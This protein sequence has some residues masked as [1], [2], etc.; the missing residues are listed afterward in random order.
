MPI[1]PAVPDDVAAVASLEERCLGRDA[2]SQGL[3]RE[4]ITGELPTVAYLVAEHEDEVVGHAVVST[5]GDIAELQR[6]AVD[7]GQRR[8]GIATALLEAVVA[9]ARRSEADRLLLEVRKGNRGA[10]AFYARA[11]FTE[12]H[13]RPRYYADGET[14][15]VMR[16]RLDGGGD[17][18][19]AQAPAASDSSRRTASS[20]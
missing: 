5:A 15:V 17:E 18:G 11:G 3:V 8:S 19:R 12:I 10:L 7:E 9:R 14:A 20:A 16:L 1:R 2:W 6:I 4:G 13:R